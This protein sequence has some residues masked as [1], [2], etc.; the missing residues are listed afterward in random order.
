MGVKKLTDLMEI[1]LT[2]TQ[3][4][5]KVHLKY[6]PSLKK[7]LSATSYTIELSGKKYKMKRLRVPTNLSTAG[8]DA[9]I[10]RRTFS[11]TLLEF[12]DAYTEDGVTF[13]VNELVLKPELESKLKSF[14]RT[15]ASLYKQ[16]CDATKYTLK[17]EGH[18][19]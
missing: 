3:E 11:Q 17:I 10:S 8:P 16:Y 13:N 9:L 4:G 6:N 19:Y 14:A 18:L 7:L 2:P 12:I 1:S 5:Y 15:V